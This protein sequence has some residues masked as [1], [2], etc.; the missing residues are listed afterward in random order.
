MEI[1]RENVSKA[2]VEVSKQTAEKKQKVTNDK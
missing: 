1:E 2:Q